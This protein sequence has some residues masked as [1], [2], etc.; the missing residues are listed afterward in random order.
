MSANDVY[1]EPARA[2]AERAAAVQELLGRHQ[3]A[4]V[5]ISLIEGLLDRGDALPPA[6]AFAMGVAAERSRQE[7]ARLRRRF[8]RVYA[9]ME[10]KPWRRLVKAMERLQPGSGA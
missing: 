7:A 9:P 8:P 1:G 2:L 4:C 5:A 6:T 10:G 3:D